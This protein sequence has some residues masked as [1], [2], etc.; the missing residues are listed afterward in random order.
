[1]IADQEIKN[2]FQSLWDE[3]RKMARIPDNYSIPGINFIYPAAPNSF[4]NLPFLLAYSVLDGVLSEI[5]QQGVFTCRSWML[6]KKMEASVTAISWQDYNLIAEG[7]EKRNRLA[8]DSVLLS[9]VECLQ[10]IHAIERANSLAS[11]RVKSDRK[12]I[13]RKTQFKKCTANI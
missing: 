7:R 8:H 5:I 10:Y 6:G 3:I 9:K 11:G 2:E 13:T 12:Q 4:H 1:M